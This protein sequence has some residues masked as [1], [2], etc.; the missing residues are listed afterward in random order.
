MSDVTLRSLVAEEW[1]AAIV[2][3]E[4]VHLLD[5]ADR[6]MDKHPDT[7]REHGEELARRA[8]VNQLRELARRDADNGEQLS[9]GG[10]P[11]VIAVPN[12]APGRYAYVSAHK[13]TWVDLEAG[14]EIR[15]RNVEKA[16]TKADLYREALRSVRPFMEGTNKTLAEALREAQLGDVVRSAAD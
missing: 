5:I 10:F 7:V 4:R 11:R 1:D 9:L 13:A 8:L 14:M 16:Q 3:E 6:I 12:D 15:L 2:A